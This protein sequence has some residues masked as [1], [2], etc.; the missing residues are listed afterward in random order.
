MVMDFL[1]SAFNIITAVVTLASAISAATPSKKD[2]A[3]VNKYHL[4]VVNALAINF[5]NAKN[6]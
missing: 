1:L 4:P 2:D 5:G 3:F 6:K